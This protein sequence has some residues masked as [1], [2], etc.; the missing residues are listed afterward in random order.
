MA[1]AFVALP[2]LEVDVAVVGVLEDSASR[3]LPV[4]SFLFL[5]ASVTELMVEQ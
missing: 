5:I 1:V 3:F 4:V 2:E